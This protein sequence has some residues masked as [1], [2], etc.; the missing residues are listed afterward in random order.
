MTVEGEAK[1]K[2]LN[3]LWVN[4][5]RRVAVSEVLEWGRKRAGGSSLP[6]ERSSGPAQALGYTG[7]LG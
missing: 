6:C 2:G 4:L 1:R 3:L 5:R 7:Q